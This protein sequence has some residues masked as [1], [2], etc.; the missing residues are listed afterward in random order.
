M[1]RLSKIRNKGYFL[2]LAVYMHHKLKYKFSFPEKDVHFIKCYDK[3]KEI[4][5]KFK[6]CGV[7][8]HWFSWVSEHVCVKCIC[9][10]Y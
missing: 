4:A 5:E 8:K 6:I 2:R 9:D 7:T 10:N 3:K 1:V